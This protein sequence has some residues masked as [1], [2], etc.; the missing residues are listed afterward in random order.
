M[1]HLP[2]E[3]IWRNDEAMTIMHVLSHVRFLS[4]PA[5]AIAMV[6]CQVTGSSTGDDREASLQ[7]APNAPAG[8]STAS[9]PNDSNRNSPSGLTPESSAG[10]GG[11]YQVKA[12][13]AVFT[14][15][16]LR[17]DDPGPGGG[18]AILLEQNTHVEPMEDVGGRRSKVRLSDG[19]V[20]YVFTDDIEPVPVPPSVDIVP[21]LDES[22]APPAFPVSKPPK[23]VEPVDPTLL[24]E[25]NQLEMPAL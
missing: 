14:I 1:I 7:N 11:T 25:A 17:G 12:G 2:S 23:P 3:C 8:F 5:M 18:R 16:N 6:S 15:A 24:R 13:R 22:G 10:V 9:S 21:V 19:R 20:G 4:V